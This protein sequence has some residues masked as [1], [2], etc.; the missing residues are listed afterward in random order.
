MESRQTWRRRPKATVESRRRVLALYVWAQFGFDSD[1]SGTPGPLSRFAEIIE[2]VTTSI[3]QQFVES[4]KEFRNRY[5]LP[6]WDP[7]E[8]VSRLYDLES[9]L[10]EKKIE[11]MRISEEA[12]EF[13]EIARRLYRYSILGSGEQAKLDL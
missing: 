11:Q 5:N 13:A 6:E 10:D 3:A 4:V 7:E 2:N 12:E 9:F 1:E 8:E